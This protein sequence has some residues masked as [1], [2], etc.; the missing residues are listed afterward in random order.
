MLAAC[1]G[2]V[3]LV[4]GERLW[5]LWQVRRFFRQP[6]PPLKLPRLV[7]IL[8]PILSGDP[9]LADCLAANLRSR[10]ACAREYLWLLDEDDQAGIQLCQQTA[11]LHP[12]VSVQ[13]ILL[14]PPGPDENPK[15]IKLIAGLAHARGD[16][17]CVLDDDTRLPDGGLETCLAYLDQ[18]GAGLAFGLPYYISFINLWSSLVAAFVNSYS[19]LTYIP[20]LRFS[21]P[22]TI[23]GMFYLLKRSRLE[24]IGGWNGLEHIL[25]DDFAIAQ[26]VRAHG[27]TLIQTPVRHAISTFV[28]S[29]RRY[30]DLLQRWFI[31]PRASLMRYLQPHELAILYGVAFTPMFVPWLLLAGWAIWPSTLT[32]A[33]FCAYLALHFSICISINLRYLPRPTPW[34]KLWLIPLLQLVLPLQ[35]LAALVSPPR[36][37]W[38][39]HLMQAD[40]TGSFRFLR[41]RSD[42]SE[43]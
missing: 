24:Q 36:I 25:A 32:A 38:R 23:N 33:I 17:I 9:T 28:P 7:S 1:F 41:R 21:Q 27:Y 42:H 39:G 8:Q 5:K 14:P 37:I 22:V 30:L 34:H 13:I 16:V 43:P 20:Y 29:P 11:S 35:I 3:L 10:S 12:Q 19:L 18:P 31:F 2:L 4:F 26:R 40:H 6:P 15:T